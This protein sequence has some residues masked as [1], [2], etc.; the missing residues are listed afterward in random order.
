M[1]TAYQTDVGRQRHQNQDRVNL[2][3]GGSD[4][5]LAVIADGIGGNL[6]GNVAAEM[7]TTELGR[8]FQTNPPAA[9][10]ATKEW[11]RRA[12]AGVN[13]SI[14]DRAQKELAY[15]GMGTT[16]VA[17][18]FFKNQ[19]VIANIGDSRAYILHQGMLTQVTADH[20]LV[21]ELVKIGDLTEQEAARSPQKNIITRAIGI[22]TAAEVDVN[23]FTLGPQDQLLLCTDGLSKLVS[24]AAIAAVLKQPLSLT[25]KC[26]QLIDRANAAGGS[27]NITVLICATDQEN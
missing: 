9:P 27:D 3:Q 8:Y 14:L 23:Q 7:V 13:R 16:M 24:A 4:R 26:Q 18:L 2:Y 19:V 25:E 17:A 22:D 10:A 11:F 20:S 6:G 12:V 21:N 1:K 5:Q 15:Q